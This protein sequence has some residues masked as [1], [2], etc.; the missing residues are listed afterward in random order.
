MS[1]V[2]FG[3]VGSSLKS[4]SPAYQP[5][6]PPLFPVSQIITNDPELTDKIE[7]MVTTSGS[8]VSFKT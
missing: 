4:V 3:K 2:S 5:F 8:D 1:S 6:N 7:T